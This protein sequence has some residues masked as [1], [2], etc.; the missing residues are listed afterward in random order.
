MGSGANP[1]SFGQT[2][3]FTAT[4]SNSGPNGIGAPTGKVQFFLNGNPY[5]NPV[6]L[7]TGSGL[8]STATI[9]NPLTVGGLPLNA[10]S[11]PYSISAT[12]T[13]DSANFVSGSSGSLSGGQTVQEDSTSTTVTSNN[14]PAGVGQTVTFTATVTNTSTNGVG[15]PTG[16][17]QFAIN[18]VPYGSPVTQHT[19]SG[20]SSLFQITDSALAAS[21]T[22]YTVTATYSNSDGNYVSGSSGSLSGGQLINA[23]Q[24][25]TVVTANATLVSAG[26]YTT[27]L[28]STVQFTATVSNT[29]V[30]TSVPTGTVQFWVNGVAQTPMNLVQSGNTAT[31]TISYQA[32]PGGPTPVPVYAVYTSTNNNYNTS[33][34]PTVN[35]TVTGDTVSVAFTSSSNGNPTNFGQTITFPVTVTN[36]SANPVGAPTGSVQLVDNGTPV[37]TAVNLTPGSNNASTALLAY[38]LLDVSHSPHSIYVA[39]VSD[40]LRNFQSNNSASSTQSVQADPASTVVSGSP[41][42]SSFGQSV[43]FTA[44]V[45]NTNGTGYPAP[46]G[47]VQFVI[48]GVNYGSP[49]TLTPGSGNSSTATISDSVL[50]VSHS[51]HS[52]TAIY[53]NSDGNFTAGPVTGFSHTVQQADPATALSLTP[54][55]PT[56]FVF[57]QPVT[58]TATMTA[59]NSTF[60]PTVGTV[61]LYLNG[62]AFT[63][64]VTVGTWTPTTPGV[65]TVTLTTS[66]LPVKSSETIT[67]RYQGSTDLNFAAS[68]TPSNGVTVSV[69]GATI[70]AS[71]SPLPSPSNY[72]QSVTFTDTLTS[73]T[74]P[75]SAIAGTV[76]FY[77]NGSTTAAASASVT[78]NG[79]NMATA[80]YTVA[81]LPAT[82]NSVVAKFVPTTALAADLAT[83]TTP[84]SANTNHTVKADTSSATVSSSTG[85]NPSSTG[86]PVTF[87]AT[88]TN[89]NGAGYPAPTGTVQFYV[90]TGSTPVKFGSPV[91]LTAGSGDS[92][93]ASITDSALTM[94][95][96]PYTV[97]ASY[98][99]SSTNFAWDGVQNTI[100]QT[101]LKAATVT[102]VTSG[103]TASTTSATYGQQ[104][105]SFTAS[106]A[107]TP[108]PADGGTVEF[109]WNGNVLGSGTLSS[110]TA[111]A[112][113]ITLPSSMNPGVQLITAEYLGDGVTYGASTSAV[114]L[115]LTVSAAPTQVGTPT[116][117]VQ[118]N[119]STSSSFGTPVTF[120][121]L[122]SSS[123]SFWTPTGGTVTF[124]NNGST[125]LGTG[126]LT[127]GVATFTTSTLAPANYNVTAKYGGVTDFAA[128]TN[129]PTATPLRG[130][131]GQLHHN[132]SVHLDPLLH[133]RPERDL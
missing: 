124:L 92:S 12:Y 94:S 81:T 2:V 129:V 100:T 107:G 75:S 105:V 21:A 31:A 44:T 78:L 109:L 123:S 30:P 98:I 5:G 130:Q 8:S 95:G 29:S 63:G 34:S 76:N 83:G 58:F 122:V 53:V 19:V 91:S 36:V 23:D 85:T 114:P 128:N 11:T 119:P 39:Y 68:P 47:Q 42:P 61:Q 56:S 70:S 18:G 108:A 99:S 52:I 14:N 6:A 79:S 106:V 72:G 101:V 25:S 40:N 9:T 120:T 88:V 103:P 133:L 51:P 35:L 67:A 3:T 97:Y 1:S 132:Y 69:T 20:N 115:R 64:P 112:S 121:A 7:T 125:F 55:T 13:S 41:S 89:T 38:S 87:T 80:T 33:T 62:V 48:D 46:T 24:T 77:V 86:S 113:S 49:Q 84:I 127:N 45:A 43:T 102:F 50:D 59:T 93:T 126:T 65:S 104:T 57:G 10:S 116:A 71:L 111:T 96:S 22:P 4:V 73:S 16:S 110:G 26:N 32:L 118:G 17:V 28:G 90:Y 66:A 15:A 82:T 131:Q 74:I 37:S 54:A 117:T 27:S 60:S